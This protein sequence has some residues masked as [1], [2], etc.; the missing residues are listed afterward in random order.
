MTT[1]NA[2]VSQRTGGQTIHVQWGGLTGSYITAALCIPL[3][4]KHASCS[5]LINEAMNKP[6]EPNHRRRVEC[7]LNQHLNTSVRFLGDRLDTDAYT[8][9]HIDED[10]H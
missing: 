6:D 1:N 5:L 2:P 4:I 8:V 7:L 9:L 10:H 3:S